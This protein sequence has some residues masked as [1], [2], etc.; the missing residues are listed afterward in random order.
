MI[1]EIDIKD[2]AEY[3]NLTSET[4]VYP[5]ERALE[6]LS[7]GLAAEVG[8]FCS[9]VA[10]TFRKDKELDKEAAAQELGDVLW[11]VA[12]SCQMLGYDMATV[13]TM[14]INKLLDRKERGVLKGDG[15][16]R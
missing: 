4:A 15:D 11:F 8:E 12:Q 16:N 9:K 2:F 6:Y 5:K 10:K 13:A 7:T 1:S 14:N 3:Q